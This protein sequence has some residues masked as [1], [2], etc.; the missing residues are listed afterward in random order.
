MSCYDIVISFT[1]SPGIWHGYVDVILNDNIAISVL[2]SPHTSAGEETQNL[3]SDEDLHSEEGPPASKRA[4][5][6]DQAAENDAMD[7][8]IPDRL[9]AETIT[10]AFVCTNSNSELSGWL[11][12]TFACTGE[13]VSVYLYDPK[14]DM[15]LQCD[16]ELPLW[17]TGYFCIDSII[18]IWMFLNFTIFTFKNL[19]DYFEV[20]KSNFHCHVKRKLR[21]Y[22]SLQS[23]HI[24][25]VSFISGEAFHKSML[26][27]YRRFGKKAVK[28]EN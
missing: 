20:E 23:S 1:G 10:N 5:N 9:I 3:E 12:P 17:D 2:P 22:R 27:K 11:I 26:C 25:N 13:D 7:T 19:G 6:R 28:K 15:L 21:S 16:S 18:K 4:C 8:N 14:H 24:S